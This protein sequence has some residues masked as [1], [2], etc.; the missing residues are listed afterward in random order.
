[1]DGLSVSMSMAMDILT[2]LPT[3]IL[4]VLVQVSVGVANIFSSTMD[5]SATESIL[6]VVQGH[7]GNP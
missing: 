4:I 6:S 1:M 5:D 2:E 7:Q 3:D